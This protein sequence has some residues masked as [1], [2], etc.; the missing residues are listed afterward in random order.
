MFRLDFRLTS[1]DF[2][3]ETQ[4]FEL[5][6]LLICEIRRI[7][8]SRKNFEAGEN[9]AARRDGSDFALEAE[10]SIPLA[11][12]EEWRKLRIGYPLS[13][14]A[15][16]DSL[17]WQFDD[18]ALQ[19]FRNGKLLNEN[20]VCAEVH[21]TPALPVSRH[22]AV[23][24]LHGSDPTGSRNAGYPRV[25]TAPAHLWTPS[26][27]NAWVG[28]TST[29]TFHGEYHLFYLLDRRHH[30]S[31]A[32][33]GGHYWAHLATRDFKTWRDDGIVVEPENFYQT[34]GTGTP[35]ERNGEL[36]IAYGLHTSRVTDNTMTPMLRERAKASGDI[37]RECDFSEGNGHIPEGATYATSSDGCHFTRSHK[38]F[39][40]TQNPSVFNLPDGRYRLFCGFTGDAGIWEAERWG[41]WKEVRAGFPPFGEASF[42]GNCLDCPSYFQWRG[43]YYL[44]VGFS[45]MWMAPDKDFL[46]PTDLAK[47]GEDL[48]DGLCVPMIST[49]PTDPDR[50]IL[51]GWLQQTGWGGLLGLR[52]LVRHSDG[53][54]GCRWLEEAMPR[55][56][57]IT[58]RVPGNG[59]FYLDVELEGTAAIRFEGEGGA[60][61]FR[62]D[63]ERRKA[64]LCHADQPEIL[65]NLERAQ[66]GRKTYPPYKDEFAV[67]KLRLPDGP[68]PV[69]ILVQYEKK[70]QGTAIDVEIAGCRTLIVFFE[71][72]KVNRISGGGVIRPVQ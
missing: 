71:G 23:G 40:W 68:V 39:H 13:E 53:V 37:A 66:N 31:K 24:H 26:F 3:E 44:V 52:E 18:H 51:A 7:D 9:Y 70:W 41:E 21:A 2:T 16:G 35:F 34:F 29:F 49:H 36:A 57:E 56:G 58:S 17:A 54:I 14:L 5:P 19:L 27:F 42:I 25:F 15:A 12:K 47:N 67:G 48:Y 65:T 1:L 63:A 10:L 33:C 62:L 60:A 64:Q 61:E 45:G 55:P 50:R 59:S 20:Y 69:R 72:L 6:G 22:A 30:G 46:H 43:T 28:D 38:L 11:R 4:L 32:G 8:G